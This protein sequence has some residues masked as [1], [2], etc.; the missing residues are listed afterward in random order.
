MTDPPAVLL[1]GQ[2]TNHSLV[3]LLQGRKRY[4]QTEDANTVIIQDERYPG[5]WICRVEN[6]PCLFERAHSAQVRNQ[7]DT[8]PEGSWRTIGRDTASQYSLKHI[9][10]SPLTEEYLN[11][12]KFR[13]WDEMLKDIK[14]TVG[15]PAGLYYDFG[16][17]TG[18]M[19]KRLQGLSPKMRVVGF[20]LNPEMIAAAKQQCNECDFRRMNLAN[21]DLEDT[22][23]EKAD[24]KIH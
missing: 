7:V 18:S 21:L 23:L 19:S 10:F 14:Q 11:Q 9:T 12:E 22:S 16:C 2:N 20:D 24:G 6:G 8:P 17:G 13:P 4:V 1:E 5:G 15:I 3:F